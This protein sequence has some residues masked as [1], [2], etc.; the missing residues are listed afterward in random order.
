MTAAATA[1][2]LLDQ[3]VR[4]S[5]ATVVLDLAMVDLAPE[6]VV[7]FLR[8]LRPEIRR[9]VVAEEPSDTH[10]RVLE[11]GVYSYTASH[12]PVRLVKAIEAS[13]RRPAAEGRAA[14]TQDVEYLPEMEKYQWKVYKDPLSVRLRALADRL[15]EI[16]AR[17]HTGPGSNEGLGEELFETT[18]GY[19]ER[20]DPRTYDTCG[21]REFCDSV[22]EPTPWFDE[23][24][25]EGKDVPPTSPLIR[26]YAMD[27]DIPIDTFVRRWSWGILRRLAGRYPGGRWKGLAPDVRKELERFVG[28]HLFRAP[29]CGKTTLCGHAVRRA[30]LRD[31]LA[32]V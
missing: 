10:R 11:E 12:D 30:G 9:I 28:Q 23:K 7:R 29:I 24:A 15:A 19:L 13:L 21:F 18:V 1:A 27:L 17:H 14:S 8:R 3:A 22:L 5:P 32:A 20:F 16:A 4:G 6:M 26:R 31:E 25:A 2:D